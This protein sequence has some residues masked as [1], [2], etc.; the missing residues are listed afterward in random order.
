VTVGEGHGIEE[1]LGAGL[2]PAR[3]LL[4]SMPD[5]ALVIDREGRILYVNREVPGQELVGTS[6]FQHDLG[7]DAEARMRA[8]LHQVFTQGKPMSY[9]VESGEEGDTVWYVSRWSPIERDGDV[10]AGLIV[11]SD[12]TRQVML[13]R[14]DMSGQDVILD[15]A[16]EGI[17]GID[18][19]GR[20]TFANAAA[21]DLLGISQAELRGRN[22]H[23][24]V[25][26]GAG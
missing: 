16:A 3:L 17:L 6:L 18:A 11:A 2:E 24:V 23:D 4:G 19:G 20:V 12:V 26:A 8:A 22:I 9:E 15:S 7:A 21:T 13:E 1:L 14:L 5:L 10:V 25:H